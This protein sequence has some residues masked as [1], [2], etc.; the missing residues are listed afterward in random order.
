LTRGCASERIGATGMTDPQTTSR[1]AVPLR[2]VVLVALAAAVVLTLA[3]V[4][5]GLEAVDDAL[6]KPWL[7]VAVGVFVVVATVPVLSRA[8]LLVL[9]AG[10]VALLALVG[11]N[12]LFGLVV[13]WR[14]SITAGLAVAVVVFAFVAFVYLV[15]TWVRPKQDAVS[16]PRLGVALVG[17]ILLSI[18]VV[19]GLPPLFAELSTRAVDSPAAPPVAERIG[20][21]LDVLIV[22]DRRA[23]GE[24]SVPEVPQG[25]FLPVYSRAVDLDV[26]Y[27]VGIAEGRKVKWTNTG[28]AKAQEARAAIVSPGVEDTPAPKP[29]PGADRVI[30]LSVDGTPPVTPAPDKLRSIDGLGALQR[31]KAIATAVRGA[32]WEDT[33]VYALLQST[34]DAR[35]GEWGDSFSRLGGVVS[36]QRFGSQTIT[37]SAVRLGLATPTAQDDFWLAMKHRPILVFDSGEPVPRPLSVEQLFSDKDVRQCSDLESGG[38]CG[39]DQVVEKPADLRSPGMHLVIDKPNGLAKLAETEH[40]LWARGVIALPVGRA[41]TATVVAQPDQPGEGPPGTPP[42][43][44][45][46]PGR[47]PEDPR[48]LLGHGSRIYVHPV[49][50]TQGKRRLVYLDYWWYLADNPARSANGAFC[51]AGLVI[52]GVTCFDHE[53]DWEGITVVL[54]R[55]GDDWTPIAAHYAQHE[56]VVRYDWEDLRRHWDTDEGLADVRERLTDFA[57]RPVV[58][59]ASGT[60]ASYAR[61]CRKH[62]K[63]VASGLEEK[64]TNGERVWVGDDTAVCLRVSCLLPLPTASGGSGPASWNAFRG[65]WGRR[66]CEWTYYCESGTPPPAPGQQDRYQDP[67]RFDGA[68]DVTTGHYEEQ[69]G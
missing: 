1:A 20:A 25:G 23:V 45:L 67:A 16:K 9:C 34:D 19:I 27:S 3:L 64:R 29:R 12:V 6:S 50:I 62:C 17:S 57:D 24:R 37:D 63:Q 49:A 68:A 40:G 44:A 15:L 39:D 30:V 56:A 5:T 54:Q 66:R 32:G 22:T 4:G 52:L 21:D 53:S 47:T 8:A 10:V 33:P 42:A 38:T 31:W 11:F 58:F 41:T 35:L 14:F 51:G 65:S 69:D 60:H 7:P 13:D 26:R 36:V 18:A 61:R 2:R 55:G 48:R 46:Q 43:T 59:V 28:I